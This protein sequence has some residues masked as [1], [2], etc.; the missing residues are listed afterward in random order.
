M[1][2]MFSINLVQVLMSIKPILSFVFYM[3]H[4]PQLVQ[5]VRW[6]L[7]IQTTKGL[8]A[9]HDFLRQFH[10]EAVGLES[11]GVYWR[12]V[13]H[14]LCDDFELILAQP[15]HMKA[16]PS[17]KTDKKDA[18]WIAKLTRIGLLP[19]SFVPDDT[20]QEL[21]ELTR[22]RKHYVESRNRETNCIH[23]IL[24]SGGIKITTY[25]ED[26]MGASGRHLLQLLI[27]E[28]PI[29]PHCPSISLSH[30][31]EESATTS[32]SLGWLFL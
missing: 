1:S 2:W 20:I 23:K 22:Q 24:Q 7:L 4:L 28:T 25:I 32:G 21:R 12:P 11:T 10:V 8:R 18:H 15:A 31:E 6:Q 3:G 9:C 29:T 13:W 30:L 14:A 19:R 5:S 16:I 27:D 26:I 17:Q